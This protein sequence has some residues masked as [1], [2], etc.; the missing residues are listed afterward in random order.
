M[1]GEKKKERRETWK[2]DNILA[3][4]YCYLQEY[5]T[6]LCQM[7]RELAKHEKKTKYASQAVKVRF[8]PQNPC[9]QSGR[10]QHFSHPSQV[11]QV[12]PRGPMWLQG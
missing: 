2:T 8:S 4:L 9:H 1:G 10:N 11:I 12:I 6:I 5:N 3:Q 7:V